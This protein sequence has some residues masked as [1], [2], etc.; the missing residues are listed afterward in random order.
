MGV[1]TSKGISNQNT[2]LR[3]TSGPIEPGSASFSVARGDGGELNS[4]HSPT[5]A[6]A[7]RDLSMALDRL[8]NILDEVSLNLLEP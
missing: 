5:V 8:A 7:L 6:D 2:S 4:K 3:G 1:E